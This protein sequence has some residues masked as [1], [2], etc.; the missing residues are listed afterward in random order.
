MKSPKVD[1]DSSLRLRSSSSLSSQAT[2]VRCGG[3]FEDMEALREDT[4]K[5]RL[6]KL[7]AFPLVVLS[8]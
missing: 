8:K 5:V 1:S 4:G 6:E 2:Q 3:S 7:V